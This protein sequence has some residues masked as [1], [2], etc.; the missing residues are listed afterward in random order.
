MTGER[1]PDTTP[2]PAFIF[3]FNAPS[4]I[5]SALHVADVEPDELEEPVPHILLTTFCKVAWM[6]ATCICAF[7]ARLVLEEIEVRLLLKSV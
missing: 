7:C 2:L 1:I 4:C 5:R 6:E 3:E